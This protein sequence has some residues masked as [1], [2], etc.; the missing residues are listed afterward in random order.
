MI[1]FNDQNEMKKYIS[2][3]EGQGKIQTHVIEISSPTLLK[4]SQPSKLESGWLMVACVTICMIGAFALG[5]F[6]GGV[7]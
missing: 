3:L 7:N 2:E 6:V 1:Y 5:L 4:A